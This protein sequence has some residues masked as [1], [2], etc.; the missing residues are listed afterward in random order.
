[1]D[2]SNMADTHNQNYVF[3]KF[4]ISHHGRGSSPSSCCTVAQELKNQL[5]LPQEQSEED[6]PGRF[7]HEFHGRSAN[8]Y[9]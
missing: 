3:L 1:M 2:M 7:C 6:K 5:G 9:W 4:D 8:N